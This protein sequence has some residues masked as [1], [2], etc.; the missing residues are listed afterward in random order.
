MPETKKKN[1]SLLPIAIIAAVVFVAVVIWAISKKSPSDNTLIAQ[2]DNY[3]IHTHQAAPHPESD[4][5]AEPA[6]PI[7]TPTA[8][9]VTTTPP[10]TPV[11]PSPPVA[12]VATPSLRKIIAAAR[13]WQPVYYNWQG[14]T[15]PDFALSD[16]N[17]KLHKLS[18][19]KGKNVLLVFWA[20]WCP[21]CL[22]EIPG[23]IK[24]RNNTSEDELAILAISDERL[25]KIKNFASK[26]GINYTVLLDTGKMR[27]P[28]GFQRA[29]RSVGVPC[30]LF[31]DP[32]GKIKLTT[33]GMVS[34]PEVIA[35]LQAKN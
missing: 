32:E 4:D 12:P 7:E 31:I 18:D 27:P 33:A 26:A 10:D 3:H 35:I 29:Y 16:L 14:K 17:G 13:T 28:Y 15:A 30:S 20:T 6:N 25:S 34:L 11:A 23:L 8:A 19:Y 1:A 5:M 22:T 9:P 2:D 21:P 24:L